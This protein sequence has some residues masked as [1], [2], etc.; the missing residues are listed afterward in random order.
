MVSSSV[1][2]QAIYDTN[3]ERM[4][5]S[6][7][8]VG[9][10]CTSQ[11]NWSFSY[12]CT[13]GAI[14]HLGISRICHDCMWKVVAEWQDVGFLASGGDKLNPGPETSLDLSELLCNKVLLKYKGDRETFW[15][16]HQKGVERVPL[17]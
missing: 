9:K 17:Y 1:T 7:S 14:G 6:V 13:Q 15:H 8:A 3:G 16:S 2:A 11:R 4:L 10:T 12:A 5:S